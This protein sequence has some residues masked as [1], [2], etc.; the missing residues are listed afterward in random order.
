MDWKSW[1]AHAFAVEKASDIDPTPEQREIVDRLC[2]EVVRRRLATPALM[3][4]E[5]SR[6][7]NGVS[8]ATMHLFQP[9]IAAVMNTAS[10][11]QFA[12]FLEHRGSID[13]LCRRIQHFESEAK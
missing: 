1:F 12:R 11:E 7:F 2:A 8:A 6:P 5:M 10:Y 3:G 13:Y 4:L 9:V